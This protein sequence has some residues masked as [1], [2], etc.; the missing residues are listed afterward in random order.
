MLIAFC[1]S[2]LFLISYVIYHYHGPQ[3]KYGDID[4]NL[5]LDAAEIAAVGFTRTIYYIILF[6]HIILAAVVVPFVLFAI[7]FGI[8]NQLGK[9]VKIVKWTF[10]IWLYVAVT[11]VIIY[12]MI[13]P[14]YRA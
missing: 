10:P 14:Y 5:A 11:G 2:S 6:T 13:S 3:T 7:Y 1:L 9:H 4:H 8:S 12:L